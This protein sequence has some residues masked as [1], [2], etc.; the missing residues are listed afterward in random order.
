MSNNSIA[1][2]SRNF[3]FTIYIITLINHERLGGRHLGTDSLWHNSERGLVSLVSTGS[4]CVLVARRY[5]YS[6]IFARCIR[7]EEFLRPL[8]G[9][10]FY[11]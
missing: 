1:I 11:K 9:R 8:R 3:G 6:N 2:R 7:A 4:G 5:V 10:H